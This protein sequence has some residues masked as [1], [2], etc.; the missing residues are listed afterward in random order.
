MRGVWARPHVV[1]KFDSHSGSAMD[2]GDNRTLFR[3]GEFPAQQ[4]FVPYE[5]CNVSIESG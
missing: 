2:S 5:F 4:T 1:G 3:G